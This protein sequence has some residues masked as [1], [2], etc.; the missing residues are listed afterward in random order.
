MTAMQIE[1]DGAW[2]AQR[3]AGAG[4]ND[5]E[6]ANAMAMLVRGGLIGTALCWLWQGLRGA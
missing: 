2:M 5:W 1:S 6:H 3:L 4:L